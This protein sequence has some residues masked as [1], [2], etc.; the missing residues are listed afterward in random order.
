VVRWIYRFSCTLTLSNS[1]KYYNLIPTKQTLA[2]TLTLTPTQTNPHPSLSPNPSPSFCICQGMKVHEMP[3][4]YL[5]VQEDTWHITQFCWS[6]IWRPRKSLVIRFAI[7]LQQFE[8]Q[9]WS[10]TNTNTPT[11]V[12]NNRH[13]PTI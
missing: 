3:V 7:D 9:V 8:S 11:G 12:I 1:T 4:Q 6:K 5:T 10:S 13:I 2:L